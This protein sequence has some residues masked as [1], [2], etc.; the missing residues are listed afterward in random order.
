MCV[1]NHCCTDAEYA[2]ADMASSL[3]YCVTDQMALTSYLVAQAH[4]LNNIVFYG[5][6]LSGQTII[7]AQIKEKIAVCSNVLKVGLAAVH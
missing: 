1:Y 6:Y 4:S 2:E 7:M 3:L 5:S